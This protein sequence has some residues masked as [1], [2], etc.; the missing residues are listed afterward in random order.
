MKTLLYLYKENVEYVHMCTFSHTNKYKHART[1]REREQEKQHHVIQVSQKVV[2]TREGRGK[3][4]P[5]PLV[6]EVMTQAADHQ[7][8]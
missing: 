3:L 7:G 1:E 4:G 6:I 8:Q 5:L 2:T